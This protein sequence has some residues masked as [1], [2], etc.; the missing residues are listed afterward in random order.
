MGEAAAIVQT[1]G[2]DSTVTMPSFSTRGNVALVNEPWY[3]QVSPAG[4]WSCRTDRTQDW[5]PPL[6][7]SER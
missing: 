7:Y 6:H 1:D 5:L 3:L 2:H 4:A